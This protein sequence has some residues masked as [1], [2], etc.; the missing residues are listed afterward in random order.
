M[1][2]LAAAAL[3]CALLALAAVPAFAAAETFVIDSAADTGG[4]TGCRTGGPGECTLRSA[5]TAANLAAAPDRITFG[6]LVFDGLPGEAELEP[7][8]P[9]PTIIHPLEIDGSGCEIFNHYDKPCLSIK[10][11]AGAGLKVESANVA[12]RGVAFGGGTA[13]I[14]VAAGST[15]FEATGDWFGLN[16]L[17]EPTTIG[18]PGIALGAG[19]DA[20]KIGGTEVAERN[21]F[22]N[23]PVGLKIEGASL[24]KVLGN[25]IGVGPEG[26][27]GA[28]TEAAVRIVDSATTKAEFNEVGGTLTIPQLDTHRCVGPCNVIATQDGR[29]VDLGGDESEAL[30]AAS[31][32]TVVRGNY[33]G[34][35][36]DGSTVVAHNTYGV[37][38]APAEP[39]CN[40]G[41]GQVTIGGHEPGEANYI[42]S[43]LEGIYAEGASQFSAIG[44]V[45]GIAPDSS[46][47]E[48]PE[49]I[50]IGLCNGGAVQ[51]AR[52]E[53]NQM[54][55]A[56]GV[57]GIESGNGHAQIVGNSVEGGASGIIARGS[58]AG[59]LIEG[60]H[61]GGAEVAGV[62][63]E[64][65]S[66]NEVFGNTITGS[67]FAIEVVEGEGNKIGGD[68]P[69]QANTLISN[70]K[71]S[72]PIS[73]AILL[74]GSGMSRNEVAANNGFGNANAFIQLLS[75]SAGEKPN[76]I[77]PP[78]LT[79][80]GLAKAVGTAAPGATVRV[81]A[82]ASVE[83]G[84]LG[85]LL[86][87]V[88]A[89]KTTG[90][91]EATYAKQASGALIAA[92]QTSKALTPEAGTS[93]LTPAY[94]TSLSP[95]E[96]KEAKE[97]EE[98]EAAEK[99]AKEKEAAE[100][101]AAEKAAKERQE[102]E[103]QEQRDR[104][105]RERESGSGGGGGGSPSGGGNSGGGSPT[106]TPTPSPVAKTAP[107]VKITA[108]PKKSST[109]TTAKFKFKA[110]NVAGAKF[111]CKLDGAKWAGCKS[112][113]TYKGLKPRSHTFAVRA[114]AAG[115][116]GPV[117]K[118]RF[119]VRT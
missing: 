72:E 110:T 119:T 118:Y 103:A 15:G 68:A 76:E 18:G 82:K 59:N 94:V 37:F 57:F 91:W 9:L 39:G 44:N 60:N 75:P 93:E 26:E 17:P 83:V 5:I 42:E 112:P 106:P 84:E 99:A 108:G 58:S 96:A 24:A 114:V 56:A 101:D 50:A 13:G 116:T 54:S 43:G 69:D 20:A 100:K 21:V 77:A 8:T 117:T 92:T 32:P 51:P 22:T 64:S 74:F 107:K 109:A 98:R 16:L 80:S 38:A 97:Q 66:D 1:R 3:A 78:V 41:P 67:L 46:P 34:L 71:S 87:V 88:P 14:E 95:Q 48:S 4:P 40:S 81:F 7:A 105:A 104:E 19:A 6:H 31:G 28:L 115:L 10:A 52:I 27:E 2:R 45:F 111:E 102:K 55:L 36:A 62:L 61:V 113:K 49:A 63:L 33:L 79:T 47:S 90:A 53:G 23:A 30:P 12:I 73:G 85:K 70:G 35:A 65:D 89:D 29:G 86:A 25:F 11:P